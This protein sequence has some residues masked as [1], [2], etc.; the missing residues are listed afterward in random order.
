L[1]YA[2]HHATVEKHLLEL[3]GSWW[4]L[5]NIVD[6]SADAGNFVDNS[7]G[8]TTKELSVKVEPVSGHI[9]GSLNGTESNNLVV[10]SLVAHDTN[11]ANWEKSSKSL[12]DLAVKTGSL[13]LLDEDVVGLAGNIDLFGSDLSENTDGDTWSWEGMSPDKVLWD[14]KVGSELT[15][16]IL[17]ELTERLNELEVHVFE[18]TTNILSIR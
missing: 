8:N 6:N 9:I 12:G 1:K 11:S 17:E 3:N 16:L 10:N 5:G 4:L 13:D 18:K 15:D 14:A 2:T 7:G